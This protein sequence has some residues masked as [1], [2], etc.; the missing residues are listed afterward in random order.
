MLRIYETRG[1]L[2]PA[3]TPG[4]TR[5]YSERDLERIGRITMYLDAGLNLAGIE[6]VLV[7]EAE[8]DDLRDQVRD[9]GGRPRRRR[10]S[11]G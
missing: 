8:T 2:M 6:R 9:L 1:L 3:R 4:G 11:P 7:L 5:R 10:R